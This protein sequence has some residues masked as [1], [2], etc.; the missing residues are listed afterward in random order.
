MR[1]KQPRVKD[2]AHL[3]F[4]RSLPCVSCGNDTATEAAHLRAGNLNYGKRP[5]GLQEKPSD[6]WTLPLC[7]KCHRDQHEGDEE[8][9]WAIRFINPWVLAM[10]LHGVSGDHDT[11]ME[12]LRRS[13]SGVI[14]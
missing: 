3:D 12:V 7:S 6:K 2:E 11:A 1:L 13:G 14:R 4:I 10:T 9:F 8:F 5:T